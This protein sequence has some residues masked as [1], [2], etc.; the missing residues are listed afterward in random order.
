MSAEELKGSAVILHLIKVVNNAVW[1]ALPA[2]FTAAPHRLQAMQAMMDAVDSILTAVET[3]AMNWMPESDLWFSVPAGSAFVYDMGLQVEQALMLVL[4]QKRR[5][6][7]SPFGPLK[8]LELSS[9]VLQRGPL[10]QP[11]SE[12]IARPEHQLGITFIFGQPST[13][14]GILRSA[15][16]LTPAGIVTNYWSV[17]GS[18]VIQ[19]AMRGEFP[20]SSWV[21]AGRKEAVNVP[22][23]WRKLAKLPEYITA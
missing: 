1:P 20:P 23:M 15:L 12:L 7:D 5:P 13:R 22:E 21:P 6:G 8:P 14:K 16:H 2:G 17:S 3:C 18:N 4:N 10:A 9:I 19:A 11:L